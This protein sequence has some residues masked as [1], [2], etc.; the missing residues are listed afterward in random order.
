VTLTLHRGGVLRV[1]LS[2]TAGRPPAGTQ[3]RV[4]PRH[5]PGAED[6]EAGFAIEEVTDDEGGWRVRLPAGRYVLEAV[7]PE[8]DGKVLAQ[9]EVTLA[10]GQTTR[11]EL[12]AP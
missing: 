4:G 3:L 7:S 8:A 9:G 5:R 12:K 6:P 1:V 11:L 2:A 10:E